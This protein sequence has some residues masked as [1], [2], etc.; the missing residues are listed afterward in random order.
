[1]GGRSS[2]FRKHSGGTASVKPK[3]QGLQKNG[4]YIDE[5]NVYTREKLK[6]GLKPFVNAR[7]D[8]EKN[9]KSAKEELARQMKHVKG[10]KHPNKRSLDKLDEASSKVEETNRILRNR[11]NE[12]N[13][14]RVRYGLNHE[15]D[16]KD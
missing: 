5:G 7:K 14:Y 1:M 8:A 13:K 15:S 6:S 12:E 4:S 11:Y 3:K 16:Y 10:L 2:S 9:L